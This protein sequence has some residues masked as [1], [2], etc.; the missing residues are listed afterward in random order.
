MVK[1]HSC[2][3]G[4]FSDIWSWERSIYK[5]QTQSE[6]GTGEDITDNIKSILKRE[7]NFI[8]LHVETNNVASMT[9]RDIL[10][11]LIK[12][13]GCYFSLGGHRNVTFGFF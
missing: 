4:G 10:N 8:I 5:K 9:S 7:P 3:S 2:S 11:R 12:L 6:G 1:G 13:K